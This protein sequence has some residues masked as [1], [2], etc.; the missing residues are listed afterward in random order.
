MLVLEAGSPGS[1]LLASGTMEAGAG[2][3]GGLLSFE[4]AMV[5]DMF[6][7]ERCDVF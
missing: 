3:A 1:K 4:E 7:E 5:A 2:V 6:G